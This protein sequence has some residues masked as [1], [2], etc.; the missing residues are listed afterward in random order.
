AGQLD[1]TSHKWTSQAYEILK[2]VE[3]SEVFFN[4]YYP[5]KGRENII[6]RTIKWQKQEVE[7]KRAENKQ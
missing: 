5:P 3:L 4:A 1:F 2:D 6:E 7:R